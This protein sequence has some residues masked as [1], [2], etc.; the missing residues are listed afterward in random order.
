MLTPKL[1]S[2]DE[3]DVDQD[4]KEVIKTHGLPWLTSSVQEFKWK[5]D[6]SILKEKSPQAKRQM[7]ERVEGLLSLCPVP[8]KDEY[9]AWVLDL[10]SE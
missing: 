8:K 6:E 7:K 2:S 4:G 9:P 5:L 10:G 3:S 1:T